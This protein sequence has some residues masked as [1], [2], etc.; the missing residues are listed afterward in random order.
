VTPVANKYKTGY[1]V[2]WLIL[3]SFLG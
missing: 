3:K 2:S 1:V